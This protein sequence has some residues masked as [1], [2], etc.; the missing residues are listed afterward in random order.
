LTG[1]RR[2]RAIDLE[3]GL[4]VDQL[5]G[6]LEDVAKIAHDF[7]ARG[8]YV[9]DLPVN[10]RWSASDGDTCLSPAYERDTAWV[11]VAC[12]AG[13]QPYGPFLRAIEGALLARGGR[14]H[15]GK[16]AWQ[17][18]G[19]NA[20]P[21]AIRHFWTIRDRLDPERRFVNPHLEALGF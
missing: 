8:A 19:Q 3:H 9:L 13:R 16:V 2:F 11:D 7:E 21:G 1:Y 17:Q 18:P 12:Y 6:A 15:P 4:P 10:I 5:E 14:P 20:D